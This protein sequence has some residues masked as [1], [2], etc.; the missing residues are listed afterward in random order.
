MMPHYKK[1]GEIMHIKAG[2]KLHN[3]FDIE[4]KDI[5][6]GAIIQRGHAENI[7]LNNMYAYLVNTENKTY[8]ARAYSRIKYGSGT[9]TLA[10]TRTSLFSEKGWKEKTVVEYEHNPAGTP[11][12]CK[13][14]IVILPNENVGDTLTE[15]GLAQFFNG[16]LLT[17]AMIK[18]SEGN[19]LPIGPKTS[20]QEIT[21]YSTVYAEVTLPDG[22]DLLIPSGGNAL[23][24]RLLGSANYGAISNPTSPEIEVYASADKTAT[25]A[26][27]LYTSSY[28]YKSDKTSF[29]VADSANKKSSTPR[30]RFETTEGNGK[31]WSISMAFDTIRGMFRILLPCALWEGYHFESESIGVG[32]GST[33]NFVLPWSDIN[34]TKTYAFYEDGVLLTEGTDYELS[35]TVGETSIT[36]YTAPAD[37]LPITGDWWVDYIPKD[38]KHVLDLTFSIQYSEGT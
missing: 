12:Y 8:S 13:S 5:R 4:V 19:L 10:A 28:L 38:D 30:V 14:K 33:T 37:T 21:I 34:D 31:I 25:D 6:T 7:V 29:S 36:F 3:E 26:T 1:E 2:V 22:M 9:G 35:N 15:V 23:L 32:D 17:H 16:T 24:H 20:T 18:D 11:S 27:Q